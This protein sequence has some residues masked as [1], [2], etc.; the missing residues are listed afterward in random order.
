M[1]KLGLYSILVFYGFSSI[2]ASIWVATHRLKAI[3]Y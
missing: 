2:S 3:Y 1:E